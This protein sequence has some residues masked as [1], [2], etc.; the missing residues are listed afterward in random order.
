MSE[1]YS[2]LLGSICVFLGGKWAAKR[3]FRSDQDAKR[4]A[5]RPRHLINSPGLPVSNV[6]QGG[7]KGEKLIII[8]EDSKADTDESLKNSPTPVKFLR[9]LLLWRIPSSI[10][11]IVV[12]W[13]LLVLPLLWSLSQGK[14]SLFAANLPPQ[15][16]KECAA[17]AARVVVL[18]LL[19]SRIMGR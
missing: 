3:H 8:T 16:K 18:I 7:P 14:D 13:S 15:N 9:G 2:K 5:R 19:F 17:E 6:Q 10:A 11:W 4:A 12:P 1:I